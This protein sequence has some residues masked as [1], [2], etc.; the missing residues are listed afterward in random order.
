MLD[1]TCFHSLYAC[2]SFKSPETDKLLPQKQKDE[3]KQYYSQAVDASRLSHSLDFQAAAA[4]EGSVHCGGWSAACGNPFVTEH[5]CPQ[6]PRISTSVLQNTHRHKPLARHL[7]RGVE[8]TQTP[9]SSAS[10]KSC[11]AILGEDLKIPA[12]FHSAF[13]QNLWP[14]TSLSATSVD[15]YSGFS[16]DRIRIKICSKNFSEA[17]SFTVLVYKLVWMMPIDCPGERYLQPGLDDK[18]QIPHESTEKLLLLSLEN[19]LLARAALGNSSRAQLVYSAQVHGTVEEKK[20]Q[21]RKHS[22]NHYL[23]SSEPDH[24][25]CWKF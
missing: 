19:L 8:C 14:S 1:N 9:R 22:V 18:I 20:F 4:A 3:V 6:L 11:S 17:E 2:P 21:R 10:T 13:R 12:A 24:W 15:I 7:G 5:R 25:E 16:S 23:Y